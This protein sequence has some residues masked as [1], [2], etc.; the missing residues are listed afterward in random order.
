MCVCVSLC[1]DWS[2]IFSILCRWC[3]VFLRLSPRA[4]HN[5]HLSLTVLLILVSPSW[6]VW[7]F[8]FFA[9]L[10]LVLFSLATN[11]WFIERNFK[12]IQIFYSSSQI[13]SDFIGD[14]CLGQ[15]LLWWLQNDNFPTPVLPIQLLVSSGHPRVIKRCLPNLW[16]FSSDLYW[17]KLT[18]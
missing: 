18:L 6:V 5:I 14:S 16:H 7:F 4:V 13:F 17:K 3:C 15:Y 1:I 2:Y 12:T 10:V 11:N 8:F 9:Q